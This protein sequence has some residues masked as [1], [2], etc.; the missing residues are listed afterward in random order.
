VVGGSEEGTGGTRDQPNSDVM[1]AAVDG[2]GVGGDPA[3]GRSSVAFSDPAFSLIESSVSTEVMT[4][5]RDFTWV[6]DCTKAI[7]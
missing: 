5:K 1:M 6:E 2:S 7:R 4:A 3:I